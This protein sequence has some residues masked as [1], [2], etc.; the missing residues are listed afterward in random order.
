VRALGLALLVLLAA[1]GVL[2]AWLAH[3]LGIA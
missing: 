2:L 3:V 1:T